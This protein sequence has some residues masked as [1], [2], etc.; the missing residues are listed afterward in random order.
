MTS[1]SWSEL[2]DDAQNAITDH[3]GRIMDVSHP[4]AG[5]HSDFSASLLTASGQVFVKGI[6][7]DSPNAWMHRNEARVNS[8]LPGLAPRLLWQEESAGWLLLGYEHV[9]GQH[10]DLGPGSPDL[11]LVATAV[12]EIQQA[13]TPYPPVQVS[14]FGEQW[15]R[16]SAWHLLRAEPPAELDEW[17]LDHVSMGAAMELSGMD[18]LAGDSLAHTDLH[19]LNILVG[20]R[21]RVIDWAWARTG[22]P[23]VD[24][25]FLVIRLIDAGHTPQDAER[26]AASV[27][28]WR[29]APGVALSFFAVEVLGVWE[30]LQHNKPL[31]HRAQLTDVARRWV[32]HR[33][34]E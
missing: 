19:S 16:L 26:W 4:S 24:V 15:E 17:T 9:S 29:D 22:A 34:N 2:P 32:R 10:A 23:W 14:S 3:C 7:A 25:A 11:P 28:A 21:A 31:P 8:F 30:W 1:Q 18:M 5:R 27:P 33:L 13:L 12:T 6:R 20:D